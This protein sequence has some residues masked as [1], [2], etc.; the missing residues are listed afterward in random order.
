MPEECHIMRWKAGTQS[1]ARS[2]SARECYAFVPSGAYCVRT[3]SGRCVHGGRRY[4]QEG[5][6][7]RRD[8]Y[9]KRE[10]RERGVTSPPV[11]NRICAIKG[12]L[13]QAKEMLVTSSHTL[14]FHAKSCE[15]LRRPA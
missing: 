12:R 6:G 13:P 5:K 9:E 10:K 7:M 8:I 2:K 3:Q 11:Q 14:R 15:D 1:G 4:I